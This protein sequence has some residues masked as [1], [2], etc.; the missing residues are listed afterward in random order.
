ML[1]KISTVS[2]NM[3]NYW[4]NKNMIKYVSVGKKVKL[5]EA[6]PNI[7]DIIALLKCGIKSRNAI[8]AESHGAA[9][10][11]RTILKSINSDERVAMIHFFNYFGLTILS[12]DI[13]HKSNPNKSNINLLSDDVKHFIEAINESKNVKKHLKDLDASSFS[14]RCE[15][16]ITIISEVAMTTNEIDYMKFSLR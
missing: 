13:F 8:W 2:K 9:E 15:K 12:D 5:I 16:L 10:A 3:K 11:V 6:I 4:R 1:L 14:T 7:D